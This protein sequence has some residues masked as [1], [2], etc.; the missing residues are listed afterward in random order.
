[1][2]VN[3]GCSVSCFSFR[4]S[5]DLGLVVALPPPASSPFSNEDSKA[6]R[7]KGLLKAGSELVV[8]RS[9]LLWPVAHIMMNR[10]YTPVQKVL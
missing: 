4:K 1:M 7:S 8:A 2:N 3:A 5:C 9:L 10:T 6:Q